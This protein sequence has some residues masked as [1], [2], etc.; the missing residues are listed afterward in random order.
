MTEFQ[1]VFS[2][3]ITE[4]LSAVIAQ[5]QFRELGQKCK[6]IFVRFFDSNENFK[7]CFREFLT[8]SQGNAYL[9]K[10]NSTTLCLL[11]DG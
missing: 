9:N 8:F 6:I 5:T 11:F 3:S 2:I 7:I 1:K 4:R 10:K